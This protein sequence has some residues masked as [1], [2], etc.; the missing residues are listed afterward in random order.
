M[1]PLTCGK[2]QSDGGRHVWEKR[3]FFSQTSSLAHLSTDMISPSELTLATAEAS[4]CGRHRDASC[5]GRGGDSGSMG[6]PK[7]DAGRVAAPLTEEFRSA[8]SRA[9]SRAASSAVVRVRPPPARPWHAEASRA[10]PVACDTSPRASRNVSMTPPLTQSSRTSVTSAPTSPARV[11][12][13]RAHPVVAPPL[14]CAAAPPLR[15]PA[16]WGLGSR[17][18]HAM[19]PYSPRTSSDGPPLPP[20]HTAWAPP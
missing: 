10:G 12:S 7:S 1:H 9:P 19:E 15:A 17:G 8:Q 4:E 3:L 20:P 18:H 5:V 2:T 11:S 14:P 16:R 6:E 13:M